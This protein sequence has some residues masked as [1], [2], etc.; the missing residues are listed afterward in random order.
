MLKA[1]KV[2]KPVQ[3]RANIIV[4][5]HG[6]TDEPDADLAAAAMAAAHESP[7]RLFGWH[8]QRYIDTDMVQVTLYRD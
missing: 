5:I 2:T 3:Q 8:V 6:V 4:D 7:E 1:T